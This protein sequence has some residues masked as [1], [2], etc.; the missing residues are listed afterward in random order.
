[1][2]KKTRVLDPE[3]ELFIALKKAIEQSYNT[4]DGFLPPKG[5]P[6]PFV[7]LGE[8]SQTDDASNKSL[9]FAEVNAT[10]HVWHDNPRQRGT[11]SEMLS[12]V[13]E[14]AR[15][16][17]ETKHYCWTVSAVYQRILEDNTTTSPLMHGVL[18]ITFKQIGGK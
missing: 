2:S 13:K 12:T 9:V 15:E 10:I 5:T 6:Y 4:Y 8:F 11:V 3:Q 1:M 18:E 17:K 7:Y 14:C 16:L